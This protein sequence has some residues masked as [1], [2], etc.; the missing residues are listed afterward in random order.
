MT[1]AR[2]VVLLRGINVGKHNRL[3]MA[4]LRALL[5]DLGFTAVAT[6]LNS[7]NAVVTTPNEDPVAVA[8]QI[9][10]GITDRFGLSIRTIVRSDVQIAG[11]IERNPMPAQARQS[12]KFFHVG[13]GNPAPTQALGRIDRSTL[14]PDRFELDGDTLYA[15][16]AEGLRN[17]ALARALAARG[18]GEHVTLRNWNTVQKLLTMVDSVDL[19]QRPR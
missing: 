9:E 16:F 15:W 12:P 19:H 11:A 4:D 3:A 18:V 1:I 7:G 6:L 14:G 17:S 5:A 10:A 13:F 2:H 8:G